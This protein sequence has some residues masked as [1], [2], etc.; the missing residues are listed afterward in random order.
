MIRDHENG[1]VLELVLDRPEKKNALDA[2]MYEA[3]GRGLARAEA[4]DAIRAVLITATGDAFCAGNDIADFLARGGE[5]EAEAPACFI[6][7]LAAFPK[8][9][10]IAVGGI[11]VGIGTTMLLHADLVYAAPEA[12][13]STP[14]ARLGLV[15]EA[16]SSV[17]LPRR[18]GHARAAA[19]LM[20]GE[21][22]TASEACVS[23][24]V[25]ALVPRPDL[26]VIARE[27][28]TVLAGL[29]ADALRETKRLLR[30]DDRGVHDAIERET[31]SFARALASPEAREA[32]ASFL[33]RK[34]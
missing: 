5:A 16:G 27:K 32:F 17:L 28:A 7:A 24:L 21:T 18:V 12:T 10:V 33:N 2:G 30:G 3:L 11:A 25:N 19:M 34:R 26:D 8:P 6:R 29:P 1:G 22:V 14:F 9:L 23:G 13:F 31:A 4:S 20:L 15:P